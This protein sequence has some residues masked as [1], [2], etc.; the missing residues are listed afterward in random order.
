MKPL[1]AL[2]LGRE[3][4]ASAH[5]YRNR[6]SPLI[7]ARSSGI[8]SAENAAAEYRWRRSIGRKSLR[9]RKSRKRSWV[10]GE[11]SGAQR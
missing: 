1:D 6:Q 4:I 8:R 11:G 2:I 7:G 3:I 10:N 9:R 5:A